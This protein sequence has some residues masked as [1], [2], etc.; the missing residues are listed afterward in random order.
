MR[1]HAIGDRARVAAAACRARRRRHTASTSGACVP[2]VDAIHLDHLHAP[3]R[4]LRKN[5]IADRADVGAVERRSRQRAGEA[6]GVG[7]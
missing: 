5:A 2:G 3:L 6:L 7:R 1:R 4:H